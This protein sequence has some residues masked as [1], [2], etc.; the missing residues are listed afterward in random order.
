MSFELCVSLLAILNG[1]K[2]ANDNEYYKIKKE[3][4]LKEVE[5]E[6]DNLKKELQEKRILIVDKEN[7]LDKEDRFYNEQLYQVNNYNKEN[8][9]LRKR[10]K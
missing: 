6:L 7:N 4:N 1:I 9:L 2:V 8:G 5:Q 10:I 3:Y